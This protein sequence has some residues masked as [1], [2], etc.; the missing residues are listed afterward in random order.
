MV[1]RFTPSTLGSQTEAINTLADEVHGMSGNGTAITT[2]TAASPIVMTAAQALSG[3]YIQDTDGAFGITLPTAA[4]LVAA[5]PNVQVGSSFWFA[6]VNTGNNT[7][8]ITAG[9]GNTLGGHGTAT[10]AT[11]TSQMF[12]VKV[13]NITSGSEAVTWVPVLKTAS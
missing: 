11:A 1:D 10:L 5:M 3:M 7:T 9:T 4:L 2:N 8:T 12:L 6:M 13:T